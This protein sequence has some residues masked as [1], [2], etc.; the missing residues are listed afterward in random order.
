MGAAAAVSGRSAM[1]SVSETSVARRKL[2]ATNSRR[3]TP[4]NTDREI[5]KT[6]VS[7]RN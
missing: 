3:H 4:K 6:L 7:D 2:A 1:C 5:S